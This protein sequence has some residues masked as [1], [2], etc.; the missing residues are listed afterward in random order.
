VLQFILSPLILKFA[1]SDVLGAYSFLMQMVSWA[2][3]SDLGFGVAVGRYLAQSISVDDQH[4]QF[5]KIFTTGRTFY[6][7]SNILFALVILIFN[8]NLEKVL[9]ANSSILQDCHYSL[10]LLSI[11]VVIRTP[12]SLY[13]DSLIATQNLSTVNIITTIGVIVRLVLSLIFVIIRSDLIG[14]MFANI[15]SELVTNFLCLYVYRKK[16]PSDR[17]GWGV[18]DKELFIHMLKF[19][20]SYMIVMLSSRLSTNTD[21]II[22]GTLLGTTA[23]SIFYTSQM[24]GIMLSQVIWKIVDNSAP[25]I[26]ELYSKLLLSQLVSVYF[27][28]LKYSLLF[29]LPLG[30]GILIF[31]KTAITL[32]VGE[33]QYAGE[34]FT[35]ALSIFII[36]QVII[37]LNCAFLIAFGKVKIM[38]YSF[39]FT[40]ILKVTLSFLSARSFGISGL[41]ISSAFVDIIECLFL[42]YIVFNYLELSIKSIFNFAV[43]PAIKSCS[44]LIMIPLFSLFIT[45][46]NDWVPFIL[47]ALM[48]LILWF[49]GAIIFGISNNERDSI[50]IFVKLK[51]KNHILAFNKL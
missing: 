25:A 36:T 19:G 4:H 30:I 1:G 6:I 10:T 17:F 20:F 37:H 35:T 33:V 21:N 29:A 9:I 46:I 39:L 23:V 32:W 47:S 12:F 34:I 14:L 15:F 31:N 50:K 8:L 11:W 3:L 51:L 45:S 7:F 44:F 40:G 27:K 43:F 16:F 5:S 26:N 41:M 28:I 22:I 24:P 18:P 13:N 38:S 42:S 49:T 48:F 2:A